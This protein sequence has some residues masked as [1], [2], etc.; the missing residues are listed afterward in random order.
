MALT[1]LQKRHIDEIVKFP[2]F[3]AI[4][5]RQFQEGL[6]R[7]GCGKDDVCELLCGGWIRIVD[8]PK[9]QAMRERMIAERI[10]E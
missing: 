2:M 7:L 4:T 1:N 8:Q 9:F 6:K 5:E 3:F 10:A